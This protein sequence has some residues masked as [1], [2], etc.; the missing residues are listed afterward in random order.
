MN[1]R[2]VYN[3]LEFP[4]DHYFSGKCV[5]FAG[6]LERCSRRDAMDKL[7]FD[8]GGIPVDGNAVWVKFLVAGR[9]AETT[10]AYKEIKEMEQQ[11]FATYSPS[12]SFLIRWTVSIPRRQIRITKNQRLR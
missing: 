8:C 12:R 5:L 1:D 2:Y 7:F 9:G 10:E 6:T 4:T 11:G 3:G